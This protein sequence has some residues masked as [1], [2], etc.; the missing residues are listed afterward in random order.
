MP[1]RVKRNRIMIVAAPAGVALAGGRSVVHWG[2]ETSARGSRGPEIRGTI[3]G[4][5]AGWGGNLERIARLPRRPHPQPWPRALAPRS[6]P[7]RRSLTRPLPR[8]RRFGPVNVLVLAVWC[9]LAAGLLEVA[10]R[11]LSRWIDPTNR[12]YQVSRHFVWLAPLVYLLLFLGMGLFFAAFTRLSP[13]RGS[14]LSKRLIVG[15]AFVPAFM[16]AGPQIYTEAWVILGL[17]IA[18][19]LIPLVDRDEIALRRWLLRSFPGLVGAVLIA[20][21]VVFGG[22]RLKEWREVGSPLPPAGSPNVLLIVMDTVRADHLGHYGYYRATTPKLERLAKRGIHFD[23]VR[24]TAPWTLA[25]HASLF[26][27]RLPHELGVEWLTPL[28][29]KSL[30]LAEYLRSNGYATAGFAANT[31][32]CSYDTGLDRGFT[33]YEDYVL[34]P[35]DVFRTALVVNVAFKS[36]FGI[37][38]ETRPEF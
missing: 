22:D 36:L 3:S 27:G 10:T 1:S 21:G 11:I 38:R 24:A 8:R 7:S 25:S 19:R 17:G 12:L 37:R 28:S 31:L 16:V 20:A 2:K 9:G 26:T 18:S 29:G 23:R 5:H 32:F 35:I 4:G 30:M 13:R 34:G 33:H 14:W 6:C 15:L